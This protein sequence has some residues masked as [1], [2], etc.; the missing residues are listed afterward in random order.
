MSALY[1]VSQA[2]AVGAG[3]FSPAGSVRDY[4]LSKLVAGYKRTIASR[5]RA[6]RPDEV[7]VLP[8]GSLLV[9]PKIDGEMWF[10]VLDASQDEGQRV[11]AV[12]PN[13][14]V[15]TGDVPFLNEAREVVLPRVSG[16]LV[17]AGELFAIRR[18]A[19]PRHG[20][21]ARAL[22]GGADAEVQRVGFH[23]FDL[24]TGGDTKD[25]GPM[26]EYE[27]RLEAMR[28][29]FEGGKRVQAIKTVPVEGADRVR[30]LYGEWVEGGKGEGLVIRS[31]EIG[32]TFKLKPVFTLDAA[33]IGFTERTDEVDAVR[34]L[35]LAVMKEDGQF[36]IVGSCGNMGSLELRQELYGKLAPETI[37]SS[38]SYASSSGALYRFVKPTLV[39]EVKVTDVQNEDSAGRPIKRMVLEL[40]GDRWVPVAPMV[41]VSIL[42]PVLDRVREDKR[43]ESTDVRASQLLERVF[44]DDVDEKAE[45]V[46][47]P[48]SEVVRRE[49]WVK[50]MKG[51]QMVRKLLVW[52]T[53]K[54][55]TDPD[56]PAYVVHWTDYSPNRKDPIKRDVR[57]APDE[58][59]ATT[60]AEEMVADGV[61]RGWEPA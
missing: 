35:L 22:S 49:V 10:L 24:L 7:D 40:A 9:S 46:E 14:K 29:L 34:S 1:D 59:A 61:K 42:H 27:T 60:I 54:H 6:I 21:L 52:K 37:E 51:S 55:E 3:L 26:P 30:E 20:D 13:G 56:Y 41:G 38:Y 8:R 39:V 5:Y 33:V 18:D 11:A 53:N 31:K 16:Q 23:A 50:S 4:D 19:R 43:V 12:A 15:I 17:L 48:V 28:R 44:I 36:Q 45:K 2:S 25:P 32:R 47:R 58:A 57:L